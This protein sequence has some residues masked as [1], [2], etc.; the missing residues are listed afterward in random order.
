MARKSFD[1]N[2]SNSKRTRRRRRSGQPR[3]E[4][5]RRPRFENLEQRRMLAVI[6]VTN[7][8]DGTLAALTAAPG[9]SL[10]EALEAA[11]TDTSVGGSTAG[12]GA[13]I[14]KFDPSLSGTITL[15]PAAGVFQ[16]SD[17]VTI[18][19]LG[20]SN[21]TI[22]GNGGAT[23]SR[24]FD[25]T[26]G[27]GDVSLKGMK[28]KDGAPAAG[29]GG[30]IRSATLGLLTISDSVITGSTAPARGGAIYTAGNL[31][32]ANTTIGGT[33]VGDA[34]TAGSDGGGIYTPAGSITLTNSA[35]VGN[36]ATTGPGGGIDA[37]FGIVNLQNS[38]VVG[39]TANTSGG[40]INSTTVVGQ[41]STISGNSSTT[42]TG[43]GIDAVTIM[44]KNSTVAYNTA[45]LG[46]GGVSGS[47]V[48]LQ[49]A[50]ITKNSGGFGVG[51]IATTTSLSVHNSIIALNTTI[52]ALPDLNAPATTTVGYSLIGESGTIP[53][54]GQFAITGATPGSQNASGNYVGNAVAAMPIVLADVFGAAGG[55][56]ADNGGPTQT[57][58]LLA[59]SLAIDAGSNALAASPTKGDQRGLPFARISPFGTGKVD[60]G[61]F[62]L[63]QATAGNHDPVLANAIADQSALVDNLFAFQIPVN[64]F[65]DQDGDAL[66]YTAT[67]TGGGALPAWL[68]FN[69]A[70]RSFTGTPT[71]ADTGTISIHVTATDNKGGVV[72][73]DDFTLTVSTDPPPVVANPIPDQTAGVNVPFTFT[74]AADAFTDPNNDPLT[75]SATLAGGG[76]LPAWLTFTSGTRTFSGTPGAGDVGTIA[77][78]VTA[79][80]G[81]GNIVSDD[82][83]VNVVASE[84]PFSENFE[85]VVDPRIK[86]KSPSFATTMSNPIAGTTSYQATRNN[87][88]DRPVATV[89]FALPTTPSN[90]TNVSVNVS[91]NGGNG[92]TLWSN[93]VIV[94]DY[95]S[96]TNYK[97]A[98]VFE[99]IDKLIIG[100][101]VNGKVQYLQQKAF[102]AQ[103]NTTI[104]LSLAIN[105]GSGLVTLSSGAASLSYTYKA[106]G[107][108]T[109]GVGTINANSRFDSLNVS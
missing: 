97:F 93:A 60:M 90:V 101:V 28:L 37:T 5:S 14:I 18:M 43:G 45:V 22:D 49:N 67:L 29:N 3:A 20:T 32:L 71:A 73:S 74:F 1:N 9:I 62:E 55:A 85:G 98:G 53:N 107:T 38:S 6:T 56:L 10:R 81:H 7:L 50:T 4:F 102:P 41:Y 99:I 92:S 88:G 19:G 48:M 39:N 94:F 65:T 21:L 77:I 87:I 70:S 54:A 106:L 109:V 16:I 11:N 35:V 86:Q 59:G 46:G 89:D 24:I 66:T 58:A 96:P 61:A 100:Q 30:A 2:G 63:Q 69:P 57:I 105:H 51:G 15:S 52:G 25:I 31:L 75:Y 8:D 72:P 12:S 44:L 13:D 95:V 42:S 33:A 17:S 47:N 82:F 108:G 104:P 26:V 27:A 80:D 36:T 68:T 78:R 34:N 76:A 40:G 84:L 83:N 79:N 64:A 91:T 103:P 23:T